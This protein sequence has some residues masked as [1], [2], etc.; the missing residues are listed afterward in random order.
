MSDLQITGDDLIGQRKRRLVKL[1][2]LKQL[3]INPYPSQLNRTHTAHELH[4]KFETLE[5]ASVTVV[6]RLMAWREHGKVVFADCHDVSGKIQLFIRADELTQD[7][8]QGFLGAP[9]LQLLDVGDFIEATGTVV[10]TKSGEVSVQVQQLRIGAKSIRPLPSTLDNKEEQFRRRYVDLALHKDKRSLFVR[11]AQFWKV[12]REFMESK[13]FMEVETPILE[14]V[15]GGAD[16]RPFVTHHNDLDEDY[17]LRIS[18]ELYQKRLIGGG[19]E[20]VY[21]L[22][23]NFRNEGTDDEHLQ[24]YSQLEWYWAYANY[25]DN[26]KLVSELFIELA[27]KVY[28]KTDFE[29]RGHHFDLASEWEEIDYCSRIK[30]HF[31]IDVNTST[32]KELIA[33]LKKQGIELPGAINR[34]RLIDNVW[35]VIRKTIAGP[36]FLVNVPTFLSPLAKENSDNPL[37]SERFQVII[38]GSELGNGY[39]ELNNPL[40]QL[41]RFREQQ[42]A[43]DAG[44]TEAQMLDLDYVEMLEYGMP[45]TSGYGHSERV[46]WFFENLSGREST[47]FPL[48]RR[49]TTELTKKIYGK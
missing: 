34:N 4:T 43:R 39:S 40:T 38:A 21:T 44:D 8:K 15:T 37:V 28:G 45:P 13:G 3:G 18:T 24:E 33:L 29:S 46:F 42:A 32:E 31:G 47:L 11:K 22:G 48:M 9:D 20:K 25:R 2:T 17:Y 27:Q 7:T 10:K 5:N 35:K 36:A 14:A 19:F 16:A 26:M 12:S 41:E 30:K 1:E 23:P 49:E 6:G